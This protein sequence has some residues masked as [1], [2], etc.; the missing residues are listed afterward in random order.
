M[1][2]CFSGW[3]CEWPGAS[4]SARPDALHAVA[5]RVRPAGANLRF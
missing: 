1:D 3:N 4:S 5:E 2:P